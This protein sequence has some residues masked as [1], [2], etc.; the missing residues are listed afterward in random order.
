M[1][2]T[3]DDYTL[4][5]FDLSWENSWR[6]SPAPNNW[7]TAWVFVKY[8]LDNGEWQQSLPSNIVYLEKDLLVYKFS[9][10]YKSKS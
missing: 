8:R 4:M 7:D 3:T 2:N 9:S 5:Q 6:T 1:Q 10:F